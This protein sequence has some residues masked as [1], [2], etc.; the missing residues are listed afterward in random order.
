MPQAT[1]E[2]T[3][4][5]ARSAALIAVAEAAAAA[6]AA[7]DEQEQ[8]E[9]EAKR[10][11]QKLLEKKVAAK[12]GPK[13]NVR[14]V[15]SFTSKLSEITSEQNDRRSSQSDAV[16][17][18]V[19]AGREPAAKQFDARRGASPKKS[20]VP[21]QTSRADPDLDSK[22]A[23][24]SGVRTSSL[25]LTLIGLI[26]VL[27]I[28]LQ[29]R[30]QTHHDVHAGHIAPQPGVAHKLHKK[31]VEAPHIKHAQNAVPHE[32]NKLKFP[33]KTTTT[34]HKLE[35]A[36]FAAGKAI[37]SLKDAKPFSVYG[38]QMTRAGRGVMEQIV[39]GQ[40]FGGRVHRRTIYVH[41]SSNEST[42]ANSAAQPT[43]VAFHERGGSAMMLM[44]QLQGVVESGVAGVYFEA[45]P[46][47]E[48]SNIADWVTRSPGTALNVDDAEGV[49]DDEI[50][51]LRALATLRDLKARHI[52][53]TAVNGIDFGELIGYGVGEGGE[54]M[55]QMA[56]SS[57]TFQK[58]IGRSTALGEVF[59]R[60]EFQTDVAVD[61]LLIHGEQD[62]LYPYRGGSP[63]AQ[64]GHVVSA[65]KHFLSVEDTARYLA[66]TTAERCGEPQ[67]RPISKH[68]VQ[69]KF[70]CPTATATIFLVSEGGHDLHDVA[71]SGGVH[72]IMTDF[73]EGTK[74][75][76]NHR[77]IIR[78]VEE[79]DDDN[80]KGGDGEVSSVGG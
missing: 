58:V 63:R 49:K 51:V 48:N 27:L 28:M 64:K 80:L 24:L 69:R 54:L 35:A 44:K 6:A 21:R 55:M 42:V 75:V 61:S 17:I 20:S 46:T 47:P 59:K 26:A 53:G 74:E 79:E 60:P 13:N 38:A 43:L 50:F 41:L 11:E 52:S 67:F 3:D 66:E 31:L 12:D 78:D 23:W 62:D 5:N 22:S 4:E 70:V 56:K 72:K 29:F 16:K 25:A 19:A 57:G 65:T 30:L 10:R 14:R 1:E 34:V 45:R 68:V 77:R 8:K 33:V 9:N 76:P 36:A 40:H 7:V 32:G 39:V 15:S 73:I 2:R 37:H 18:G 71:I